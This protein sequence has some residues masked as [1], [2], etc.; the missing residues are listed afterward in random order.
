MN[1]VYENWDENENPIPNFYYLN[2]KEGLKIVPE[3]SFVD[4]LG[5][6]TL[7][8]KNCRIKDINKN[9]KF[10]FVISYAD[11]CLFFTKKGKLIFS[12]EIEH[13][14]IEND[15]KIIFISPYESPHNLIP[16]LTMLKNHIVRKKMKEEN[17]YIINNNSMLYLIKE[18]LN[19]NMN[20]FKMDSLFVL[21]TTKNEV[22]PNENNL[23]YDKKFIFLSQN[24]QPH[25]HRILLLTYLKNLNLLQDDITNWSLVMTYEEYHGANRVY[26]MIDSMKHMN[27]K[28]IN[29]SNN[30]L[31][32]DYKEIINTKK[33]DYYEDNVN[34]LDR[35]TYKLRENHSSIKSHLESYINIVAETHFS[36]MPMNVHITEKSIK[37][38][39]YFQ[40]PI[41]LSSYNH[42]KML[43]EEY[44]FY[45]FDDLIDHSY[46]D[47]I[48]DVKRFNM[49]INE[50]SRLSNMRDE[51]K[52]YYKKNIDKIL[53]NH[54]FVKN[55]TNKKT[56]EKY[57]L[58]L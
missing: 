51:I 7:E 55:H 34:L 57:F 40:M 10:Y 23:I 27:K 20:F 48:D 8:I 44:D 26:S 24:R 14:I 22:E 33:L 37:S 11:E 43:R 21:E 45:L 25:E 36:Y 30:K 6:K 32:L 2:K 15:L 52:N 12:E 28:Y 9:E 1:L 50:I 38:F 53:H 5:F 56:D 58:K 42:V 17:F 13:H 41:F 47:E 39:Y 19:S 4:D 31:V 3:L 35:N 29:V 54:F 18:K 49:V 16:F 46:D